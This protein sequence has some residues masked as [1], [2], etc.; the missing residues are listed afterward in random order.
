MNDAKLF[1]EFR[2]GTN[3]PY[4]RA[5]M[6]WYCRQHFPTR[7]HRIPVS[8][9]GPKTGVNV[10]I[11]CDQCNRTKANMTEIEFRE[12]I[13][14]GRPNKVAYMRELGLSAVEQ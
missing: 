4:C 5:P 8:R 1:A 10:I 12:W 7:E 14:R 6:Y 11:A 9:G 13:R 2:S 3:C